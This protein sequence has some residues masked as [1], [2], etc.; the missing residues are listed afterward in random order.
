MKRKLKLYTII[1]SAILALLFIATMSTYSVQKNVQITEPEQVEDFSFPLIDNTS[2]N[3]SQT[4]T[5][6]L[7]YNNSVALEEIFS[8]SAQSGSLNLVATLG[9]VKNQTDAKHGFVELFSLTKNGFTF[10]QKRDTLYLD[11]TL[12][13]ETTFLKGQFLNETQAGSTRWL[14]FLL[15]QEGAAYALDILTYANHQ[16]YHNG[17]LPINTTILQEVWDFGVFDKEN[18]QLLEV[19]LIGSNKSNQEIALVEFQIY[20]TSMALVYQQSVSWNFQASTFVGFDFFLEP[21]AAYFFVGSVAF[22]TPLYTMTTVFSIQRTAASSFTLQSNESYLFG[23]DV[24][25]AYSMKLVQLSTESNP[26]LALFGSYIPNGLDTFPNCLLVTFVN[27]IPTTNRSLRMPETPRWA[28]TGFITDLNFDAEKEL[29]LFSYDFLSSSKSDYSIFDGSTLLEVSS[30]IC[31][32]SRVKQSVTLEID[33]LQIGIILGEDESQ[34][35]ALSFHDLSFVA[36][37]LKANSNLLLIGSNNSLLLESYNLAGEVIVRTDLE[38]TL[39]LEGAITF[40]STVSALPR[41]FSFEIPEMIEQ[42]SILELTLRLSQG[43][44]IAFERTLFLPL[45]LSPEFS[46]VA[47]GSPV[48]I[49]LN[50]SITKEFSF[51]FNNKLT[52]LLICQITIISSQRTKQLQLTVQAQSEVTQTVSFTFDKPGTKR[53][54]ENITITIDSQLGKYSFDYS[55][56]IR[57]G[58]IITYTDLLTGLLVIIIVTVLGYF[59]FIVGISKYTEGQLKRYY[60]SSSKEKNIDFKVFEKQARR[61]LL[62]RSLL[63]RDWRVGLKLAQEISPQL[64]PSFQKFKAIEQLQQAQKSLQSGAINQTVKLLES[65]TEA[66]EMADMRQ[67]ATLL[68]TFLNPLKKILAAINHM[69]GLEKVAMLQ[70]EF[71]TLLNLKEQREKLYGFSFADFPYY[72]IAKELGLAFKENNDLQNALNFLQLAYQDAPNQ[73]KNEIV[74]EITDL[75][76]LGLTPK[77]LAIPENFE[78][79]KERLR[80]KEVKCFNCG[81]ERL[82]VEKVCPSCGMEVVK[83]SVCKLPIS[84]GAK[85]LEC[86][87]CQAIAHAEHLMEWVKVKGTCPVC[88]RKILLENL[89][90]IAPQT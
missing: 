28:L 16:L 10:E 5:E 78:A 90:S 36:F 1:T 70:K 44:N 86:P 64:V 52:S 57:S 14:L 13:N 84:F 65:A 18:D 77:E 40:S 81:I 73:L 67:E 30:G 26:Q 89:S 34:N 60:S 45:G 71:Q 4:T 32:L 68:A 53:Q 27:G 58:F 49:R 6:T 21:S 20:T 50:S 63:Q 83:C 8:L 19:Y 3:L 56:I 54:T 7:L 15:K 82:E 31:P 72:L 22:G 69:K 51:S 12:H 29:V 38:A 76:R 61:N 47:P 85:T 17:S 41:I 35:L 11:R 55:V 24:F 37:K 66:F 80:K 87:H 42:S 43:A 39:N 88:Q 79:I 23:S 46:V 25:R 2:F 9:S 75:I 74:L 59:A 33:G 62:R 48:A